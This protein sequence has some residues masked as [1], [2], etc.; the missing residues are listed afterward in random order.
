M[1]TMLAGKTHTFEPTILREYDVRGIVGQTLSADDARAL[2]AAFGTR[3]VRA[4]GRTAGWTSRHEPSH[5][6]WVS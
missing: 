2:G 3:L 1:T 5:A 4:G 6:R